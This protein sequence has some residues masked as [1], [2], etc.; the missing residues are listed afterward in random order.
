MADLQLI[1]PTGG[2]SIKIGSP[3]TVQWGDGVETYH[4]TL[5]KGG[6]SIMTIFSGIEDHSYEWTPVESLVTGNDYTILL[7]D[8]AAGSDERGNFT[9]YHLY[10][11]QLNES[12]GISDSAPDT[13]IN[14]FQLSENVSVN[15]SLAYKYIR[16]FAIAENIA[17]GSHVTYRI[18]EYAYNHYVYHIDKD[19]WTK[20][21]KLD[22]VKPICIAG[23]NVLENINLILSSDNKVYKYPSASYTTETAEIRTKKFFIMKGILRR[24]K[25]EYEGSPAIYSKVYNNDFA[26]P[27]YKELLLSP[28][29]DG[30]WK[31]IANGY[32]RGSA[33]E[34]IIKNADKIFSIYI[35]SKLLGRFK[36]E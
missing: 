33:F 26:S 19:R 8:G 35:E 29:S 16:Q 1:Y 25:T 27:Y 14:K 13:I 4:G 24:V 20:F 30:E 34:I 17:I 15:D 31:W 22:I 28:I 5:K 9:L 3:V 36:G 32:N 6:A 7:T 18:L 11:R 10:L 12:V 21:S 23:G 2:E